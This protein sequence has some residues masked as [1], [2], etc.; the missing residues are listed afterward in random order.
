M[1]GNQKKK[2]KFKRLSQEQSAADA[3][4]VYKA[5]AA[6]NANPIKIGV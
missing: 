3:T 1:G 6:I 2:L 5:D 4:N